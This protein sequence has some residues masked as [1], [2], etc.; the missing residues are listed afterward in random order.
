[1]RTPEQYARL[2]ARL[3]AAVINKPFLRAIELTSLWEQWRARTRLEQAIS[4]PN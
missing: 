1:M 3:L 2:L 4:C